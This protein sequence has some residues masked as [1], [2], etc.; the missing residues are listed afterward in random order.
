MVMRRGDVFWADLGEPIGSEPGFVRP[1]L[2]IQADAFNGSKLATTIV[3]SMTSNLELRK[4]PGCVLL[5]TKETGLNKDSVAN[6]T[7]LRTLDR[8][9]LGEHV[10]ELDDSAMLLIDT[11]LRRVLSI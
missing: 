8:S 10:G 4:A 5:T 9:R 1:V 6:V 7:Q 2:V 11:A 3:L